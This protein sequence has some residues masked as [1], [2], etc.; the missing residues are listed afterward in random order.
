MACC[1]S[2]DFLIAGCRL[3]FLKTPP[4]TSCSI[5]P[6]GRFAAQAQIKSVGLP[7]NISRPS[8]SE[9]K[10]SCLYNAFESAMYDKRHISA[11][12]ELS[13]IHVRKRA[14]GSPIATTTY[15]ANALLHYVDIV[16]HQWKQSRRPHVTLLNLYSIPRCM[17]LFHFRM[18]FAHNGKRFR[19]PQ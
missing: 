10:H 1:P 15:N 3:L 9:C 6:S 7:T 2:G 5:V 12:C 18:A 19:I 16:H 8:E 4:C 13:C 14:L 11:A 17:Y